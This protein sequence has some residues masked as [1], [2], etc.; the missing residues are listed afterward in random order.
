MRVP[1]SFRISLNLSMFNRLFLSYLLI[2][3]V[4]TVLISALYYY[5][6][7][8]ELAKRNHN[9]LNESLQYMSG[10]LGMLVDGINALSIQL[11]LSSDINKAIAEPDIGMY[12]Y[13]LVKRHLDSQMATNDMFYSM[14]LYSQVNDTVLTTNEGLF[15]RS[16]FYDEALLDQLLDDDGKLSGHRFRTL[17]DGTDAEPIEVFTFTRG[18]PPLN[19]YPLGQLVINVKSED[20]IKALYPENPI[21]GHLLILD[22]GKQPIYHDLGGGDPTEPE[23]AALASKSSG[24]R[25]LAEIGGK[26]YFVSETKL[27]GINWTLYRLG[28]NEAYSA[29]LHRQRTAIARVDFFVLLAGLLVSY[30]LSSIMYDPWK[31]TIAG[32]KGYFKQHPK[33]AVNEQVWVA[34]AIDSLISENEAFQSIMDRNQPIIRERFIH[35]ILNG[36]YSDKL[37]IE[38][39][40]GEMGISFPHPSFLVMIASSNPHESGHGS[41]YDSRLLMF[42]F[43]KSK[44]EQRFPIEGTVL[45]QA[46][47]GFILNVECRAMTDELKHRLREYCREVHVWVQKELNL[48]VQFTF[49]NLCGSLSKVN[50][51]CEQAKRV[52]AYKPVIHKEDTV[53]YGD[54]SSDTR[55]EY[56]M[57]IQ[58]RLLYGIAAMQRETALQ[59]LD[60]LFTDYIFNDKY[61][62]ESLQ[63]MIV[64][65]ASA[66]KNKLL[67]LGVDIETIYRQIGTA[68][69]FACSNND[70]LYEMMTRY[71]HDLFEAIES[72]QDRKTNHHYIA[73]AT[74]YIERHYMRNMSV[75]DIADHLGLSSSYLSRFFKTETGKSPLEYLTEFRLEKSKQ[76]LMAN[77]LTLQQ[78][79]E[80][81]GYPDVNSYIRYFKKYEGMTP[82]KFRS[83]A[84]PTI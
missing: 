52:F 62:R 21:P 71:I 9:A 53:F 56:P 30:L 66:I 14:Y 54:L 43:I 33:P 41:L 51:S 6:F 20:L 67:E 42:S 15:Q 35:D 37:N 69:I 8:Q 3:L 79:S 32:L 4:P 74:E 49:G 29:Q 73:K 24:E 77:D 25:T 44:F 22:S 57:S 63:E 47:F 40:L 16:D 19:S 1:Q 58:K 13:R 65:L 76:L 61:P 81:I 84:I 23:L 50:V 38:E 70:Q 26:T 2:I 39:K 7:A 48:T 83:M 78:I 59:C 55:F 60:E 27:D 82:G 18:V 11:S 80:R 34:N 28:D 68:Q 75:S 10:Q 12:D 36:S 31:K 5:S 45:E 46:D 72:L 64:L 17:R